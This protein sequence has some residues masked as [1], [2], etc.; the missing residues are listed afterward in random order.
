MIRRIMSTTNIMSRIMSAF[1]SCFDTHDIWTWYRSGMF[2]DMRW[3][4]ISTFTFITWYH[5]ISISIML[6][7]VISWHIMAYHAIFSIMWYQYHVVSCDIMWYQAT[8]GKGRE[9]TPGD[10]PPSKPQDTGT[11]VCCMDILQC[12]EYGPE[13][14]C[15]TGW[16]R[17][18]FCRRG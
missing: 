13:D 5:Y 12:K 7:H 14:F 17:H 15:P 4:T 18:V 6:Y 11:V 10:D 3:R 8:A 16:Y 2:W 1:V 9:F